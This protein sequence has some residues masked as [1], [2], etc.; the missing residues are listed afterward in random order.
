MSDRATLVPPAG[1][2][3]QSLDRGLAVLRSFSEATPRLTLSEVAKSTGLTRAAARRF[4]LTLQHLGYVASDERHFY[5]R[6]K[7]LELGY[8]YLSSTS[9]WD[10]ATPHL[11]ELVSKVHESSS[12]SVLEGQDVMYV[13]RVPT[14]RI[15]TIALAIGTRLPA[16]ATSMGRV[17][18]AALTPDEFD[19][20]LTDVDLTGYTAQTVTDKKQL[21]EVIDGVREQGWAIVDKELEDGLRSI[22]APIHKGGSVIAAI[23]VSAHASRVPLKRLQ[24]EFLPLL[25]ETASRIDADLAMWV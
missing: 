11:H 9:Q 19:A 8:A 4:L 12:V 15:M 13:A 3:V 17:L 6:P 24:R 2:F 18:L 1:E 22:A 20:W 25:Q 14:K 7:V 21:R 23:N 16:H 10:V 5:L